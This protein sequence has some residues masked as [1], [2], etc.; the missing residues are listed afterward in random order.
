MEPE[1]RSY[2]SR[3]LDE[4][5][6]ILP[7]RLRRAEQ[8]REGD[9]DA[10]RR[11]AAVFEQPA[12]I[13]L[14]LVVVA[15]SVGLPLC[16]RSIIL[17]DE[18]YLLQQSLDLLNGKVLYRDMDSF[19]TP[20]IWFLLAG[21]FA[22]FDASVLVSR[23]VVLV[24]YVATALVAYR[25]VAPL[26]TRAYGLAAAA[27]LLL[28]SVWAFP[29][30][31]F[32]F[33]SPFAVLLALWG[34]ERLLAWQRASRRRDLVIAGVLFGLAICTKQNYGVFALV[35]ACI[36][37]VAIKLAT[38]SP[39]RGVLSSA[40]AEL[41]LAGTGVILAGLPF[42]LYLVYHGAL[43]DAYDSLVVHPFEFMGRHDIPYAPLSDIWK[44]DLYKTGVDKLTYLSYAMLHAPAIPLL[45]TFRI[46]HRL[47]AL[48][49]WLAPVIFFTGA[50]L[51]LLPLRQR[52]PRCDAPLLA[53]V[54][55][56]GFLFAGV[57]P[58]ADFNHLVN[59]YQPVL[60]AA[61]LVLHRALLRLRKERG[62][63]RGLILLSVTA[64]S[65]TYGGIAIYW[66]ASLL[67]Q[68]EAPL[69]QR[70]G[71]VL[72]PRME[73]ENIDQQVRIM[74]DRS[75]E[76]E[77]VLTV[78]DL[79]MLNFLAER[80]VPSPY[81]NLYE[82]H[83]AKDQGAGVVAGAQA[84]DVG[85]VITRYDNF[86]SDRVGLLEYAPKLSSYIITHFRRTLVGAD[87]DY[88]VYQ[89]RPE[90]LPEHAFIRVL[91][92]CDWEAEEVDLRHHLLFSSLYHRSLPGREMPSDGVETICRVLIPD[93]GGVLALELGYRRPH[94][95]KLG[96][97]LHA[98][99]FVQVDGEA[100]VVLDEQLRVVR[101]QGTRIQQAYKRFEIDLSRWAGKRASFLFRTRLQGA[102][103]THPLDFKGFAMVWRDVRLQTEAGGARP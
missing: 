9:A 25:V 70:R 41:S 48:L 45:H 44:A 96:T 72:V 54:A 63:W 7:G 43:A 28:F 46:V 27:S 83:I 75:A 98:E 33:Y 2:T 31:T 11:W 99:I 58:R 92:D 95:S 57:L 38:R 81:Y 93:T 3:V 77:A 66:Y 55:T 91:D 65:F 36:G 64:L 13:Y 73:A 14:L 10:T 68:L 22:V 19:I 40:F 32:A 51:A 94:L 103:K 47:H 23:M 30:W 82:H 79:S 74:V 5:R 39:I 80:P 56:C 76:G 20:G 50:V 89:R 16:R 62:I 34:L 101:R 18:G 24:A 17:S 61:P 67:S 84:H 21:V 29:A 69:E 100:E 4:I 6:R 71:G 42:L 53:V 49:Y 97:T 59:V 102:V 86:F 52:Q 12:W 85:L 15:A 88:I 35:G 60:V 78:P 8:R 37:F 1:S 87:D 90:P 26:T